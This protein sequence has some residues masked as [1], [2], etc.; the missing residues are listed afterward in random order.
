[1][2]VITLQVFT[3]KIIATRL[4]NY[5]DQNVAQQ[6]NIFP[7]GLRKRRVDCDNF[8]WTCIRRHGSVWMFDFF[9]K[10]DHL[11]QTQFDPL[12]WITNTKIL[13]HHLCSFTLI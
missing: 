5:R 10:L 4:R 13:P 3:L 7:N 8:D 12:L 11:A 1:M 9:E 6:S 2:L